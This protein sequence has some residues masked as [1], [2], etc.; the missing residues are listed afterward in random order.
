MEYYI[1]YCLYNLLLTNKLHFKTKT[2]KQPIYYTLC[3]DV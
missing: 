3:I 1:T 2:L